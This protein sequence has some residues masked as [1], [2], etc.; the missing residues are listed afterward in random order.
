MTRVVASACGGAQHTAHSTHSIHT[1]G[2][3]PAARHQC[4]PPSP[5]RSQQQPRVRQNTARAHRAWPVVCPSL[6]PVHVITHLDALCHAVD[7]VVHQLGINPHQPVDRLVRGINRPWGWGRHTQ[8]TRVW[9]YTTHRRGGC[10]QRH[11]D[12][13]PSHAGEGGSRETKG[14]VLN[15]DIA[16]DMQQ[17]NSWCMRASRQASRP[18]PSLT[19]T[20]SPSTHS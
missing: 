13:L 6:P 1:R 17:P 19:A 10:A 2:R 12:V 18:H 11:V 20:E 16:G 8:H 15:A 3:S 5:S 7:T 4:V 9:Q 14:A